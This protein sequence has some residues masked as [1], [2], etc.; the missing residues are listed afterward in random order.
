MEGGENAGGLSENRTKCEEPETLIGVAKQA[1]VP[2]VVHTSQP[3][4]TEG[5]KAKALNNKDKEV[6]VC[7]CV[8][9]CH[10]VCA[11]LCVSLKSMDL[12]SQT[13]WRPNISLSLCRSVSLS[14]IKSPRR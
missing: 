8:C 9:V 13:C 4:G 10:S 12:I 3:V 14:L 5:M 6:C 7:V 1:P 2:V 11:S